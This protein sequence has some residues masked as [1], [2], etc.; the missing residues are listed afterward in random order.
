R[1]TRFSRDWSSDVCSS[2]LMT[3]YEHDLY[4]K[5]LPA[6]EYNKHWWE[7]V[8]KYQGI[9]APGVRGEEYCDAASK[10]HINDDAAQY[11]DYALSYRSEERRVGDE[12]GSREGVG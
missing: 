1:H 3:H 8:G 4:A 11:Y 7:L 6:N 5:N 12:W 10:T 2:D 9:S